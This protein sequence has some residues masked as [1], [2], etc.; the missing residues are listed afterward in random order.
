MAKSPPLD[1]DVSF[2]RGMNSGPRPT[3]LGLGSYAKESSTEAAALLDI[4]N[5][6]YHFITR[7]SYT[8]FI[9]RGHRIYVVEYSMAMAIQDFS[10]LVNF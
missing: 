4:T 5:G 6:L 1:S 8:G 3:S 7:R 10:S 9:F 2:L